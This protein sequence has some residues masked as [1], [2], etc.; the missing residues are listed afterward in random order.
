MTKRDYYEI[1][2]VS[3]ESSAAEIKKAYRKLALKY[4]PDR[5][6][7]DPDAESK[8]KEASEAYEVLSSPEKRRIYDMYG[9]EGLRGSGFEG[10]SNV[11]DIFSSFS[12]LFEDFFGMGGAR[13]GRTGPVKGAD[14]RYDMTIAFEEAAFG[15]KREIEFPRSVTCEKCNE[16]G[17]AEGTEPETCAQCGGKGMTGVS[18]GFFTVRTTCPSC[19]G[20]GKIVRV[21][22]ENCHGTGRATQTRTLT[23][24]IPAGVD[25]GANLRVAGEGEAGE[26]GG[27][28]GDLFVVLHVQP[29]PQFRREG[30]DI[31][32]T[33]DISFAQAAMGD[34][35]EIPVL[36]GT[37]KLQIPPGTQPGH[38]FRISDAGVP[39]L[40]GE[41]RGDHLVQVTVEVPKKLN[42]KQKEL[43]RKFEEES[44]K[45]EGVEE[46]KTEGEEWESKE[47]DEG[48]KHGKK[49]HKG[50]RE[51]SSRR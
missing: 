44:K 41:G 42:K 49:P 39:Y 34:T 8:F 27:P 30:Y 38:V 21:P 17:A 26:R 19:G 23:I 50:K 13:R 40:R 6:P 20:T 37:H 5:N 45:N 3:R 14:L 46:E 24:N 25:T 31:I 16:T 28:P 36:D 7:D 29:H 22:C 12:N 32:H 10:F 18:R 43:L 33:V 51:R 9:H 2:G 35:I 48:Q 4:H 15:T 1:L 47:A 11:A